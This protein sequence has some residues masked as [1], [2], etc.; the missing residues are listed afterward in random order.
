MKQPAMMG[1]L[2]KNY[3]TMKNHY[4]YRSYEPLGR[5]YIGC[6]TCS[7]PIDKDPYLGSFTDKNFFPTQKEIL[8]V[9]NTREESLRTEMFLHDL[10]DVGKNPMFANRA[11]QTSTGFNCQGVTGRKVSEE[12]KQK[13]REAKAGKPQTPEHK[14]KIGEA[15]IGR[16]TSENTKLKI[17][18]WH[19]GK[20]LTT[21]HRQKLSEKKVGVLWWVNELGETKFQTDCPGPEWQKGRKFTVEDN[22]L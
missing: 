15:G 11:K 18:Q 1:R 3:D 10:Y 14:R 20:T 12:S 19:T 17:S 7:C 13:M 9:C 21:E 22:P 2:V 4:V 6:R 5:S 8:A 16:V